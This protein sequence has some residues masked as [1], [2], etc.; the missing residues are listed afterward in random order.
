[1]SGERP[2]QRAPA[3]RLYYFA[4]A[5]NLA[6]KQMAERC[7]GARQ[8][9][10]AY[11]PHHKIIFTGWSRQW[12]GAT[13]TIKRV[14]G[15]RVAGAV[16]ELSAVDLQRLDRFEGYNEGMSERRNVLVVTEDGDW[17][18]AVTYVKKDQSPE[19]KPS[20]EYVATIRQG[21]RDWKIE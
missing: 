16:Y 1:M 3:G 11:L 13:A 12:R 14:Q 20:A 4:Y 15:E 7:P 10:P 19:G 6:K 17:F 2:I 8:K 5:S 21:Y 9:V 18:E